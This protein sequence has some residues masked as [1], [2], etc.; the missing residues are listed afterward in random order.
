MTRLRKHKNKRHHSE[1]TDQPS[2][3]IPADPVTQK[4]SAIPPPPGPPEVSSAAADDADVVELHP[5]TAQASFLRLI[6]GS[7]E[8]DAL[9]EPQADPVE[10]FVDVPECSACS[11]P[12]AGSAH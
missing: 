3:D 4:I 7:P 5:Q 11:D 2:S 9:P 6:S 8:Q 12:F 10:H 1:S